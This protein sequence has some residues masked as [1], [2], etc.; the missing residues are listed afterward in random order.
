VLAL[1]LGSPFGESTRLSLPTTVGCRLFPIIIA[2][3][4]HHGTG[5]SKYL[6]FATLQ[7][8][9]SHQL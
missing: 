7:V 4:E 9:L 5:F 3:F 1:P 2:S 6:R 8:W